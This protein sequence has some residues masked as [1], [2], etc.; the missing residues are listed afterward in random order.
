M[1]GARQGRVAVTFLLPPRIAR[2]IL[3]AA[4]AAQRLVSA[5]GVVQDHMIFANCK[6]LVEQV[7]KGRSKRV[8]KPRKRRNSPS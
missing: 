1:I 7:S 3:D 5:R 2:S 8:S 6:E 4:K